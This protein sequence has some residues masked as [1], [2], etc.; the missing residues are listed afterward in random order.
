MS[1]FL[2]SLRIAEKLGDTLRIASAL[3]NV[4]GLYSDNQ[5]DYHKALA[6]FWQFG[7]IADVYPLDDQSLGGYYTGIGEVY[8]NMGHYDSALFYL[9]KSLP[10]YQNTVLIPEAYIRMGMV[11]EERGEFDKAIQYQQE[12]YQ[13]AVET[14]QNLFI[15]RSLLNLGNIYQ[16]TGN[17]KEAQKA[18]LEAETHAL[19]GGLNYEL[20]D[21]YQGMSQA[22]AQQKSFDQAY[23][24]QTQSQAIK[25]TLF[26]LETDDKVRGLQFTYEIDKKQ[27]EINLL[28]KDAEIA[29]LEN[30][31]Q[32]A[33]S[34]GAGIAGVSDP[35]SCYRPIQAV[36]IH[37]ENQTR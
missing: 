10:L 4:G 22:F 36:P 12:A 26:N 15:T 29:Q 37:P 24:Y 18:Y 31:R 9:E 8:K 16:K 25:D 3:V 13:T 14:D 1:F 17:S 6:Y 11:H 2:R 23:K 5:K 35:P 21:I 27:D 30:R 28:E 32:K 34:Y 19:E 20:R 7:K 33:I